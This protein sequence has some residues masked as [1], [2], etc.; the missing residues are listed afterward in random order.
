M[1]IN[2]RGKD[3]ELTDDLKDFAEK[4]IGSLA[5]FFDNVIDIRVELEKITNHHKQGNIY[6]A[7]VEM[8]VPGEK[9]F[10]KESAEDIKDA[11]NKVKE[12][13]QQK[14]KHFKG[15]IQAK[16]RDTAKEI[17]KIKGA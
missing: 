15:Q 1:Q 17:R 5:K 14:I 7:S 13:M 11:I 6:Q 3:V 12:E 16:R 9:L 4:K 8:D 10:V 2:L